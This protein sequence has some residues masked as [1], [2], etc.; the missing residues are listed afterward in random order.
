M[1]PNFNDQ[2][3]VITIPERENVDYFIGGRKVVGNVTIKRP[4]VVYREPHRG[5]VFAR[6]AVTEYRFTPQPPKSDSSESTESEQKVDAS[7]EPV[8]VSTAGSDSE[9]TDQQA[10]KA[11]AGAR[12]S[13][14]SR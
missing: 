5:F 10:A 8:V 13:S 6:G 4:T 7:A 3:G 1:E 11:A 9:N 14:S 12:T 2:T